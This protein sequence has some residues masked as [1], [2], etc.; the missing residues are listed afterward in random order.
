MCT[1]SVLF[2][3]LVTPNLLYG[4]ETWEPSLNKANN[5][6][7]L[8]RPLVS[9]IVHIIKSKASVSHDII[10]AKMG[11]APIIIEALFQL[12]TFS[13]SFGSSLKEGTQ[14][15]HLCHQNNL[16]NMETFIVGTVK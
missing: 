13:N 12:V 8:E 6:K 14:S 7:D 10:Q 3:T 11:A 4:V 16:L 15:W 2:D 9:M 1:F 5:K